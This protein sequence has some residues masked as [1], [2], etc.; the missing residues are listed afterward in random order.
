MFDTFYVK[1]GPKP[2][3]ALSPLIFSFA[4]E[5][6]IRKVQPNQ[7][8]FKSNEAHRL[9]VRADDVNLLG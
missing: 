8:R 7:E 3:A 9:V 6:A 2:G 5:Y 1:F 4:L